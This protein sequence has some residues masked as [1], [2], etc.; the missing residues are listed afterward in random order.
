MCL[1]GHMVT[2]W[3]PPQVTNYTMVPYRALMV[4]SLSIQLAGYIADNKHVHLFCLIFICYATQKILRKYK[5]GR[6]K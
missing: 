3:S 1:F 6:L 2:V 5:I 4:I